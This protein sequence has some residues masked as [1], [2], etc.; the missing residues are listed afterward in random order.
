MELDGYCA[1]LRLAFEYNGEQHYTRV[2]HFHEDAEAFA[3][4]R[5]TDDWKV[6]LC[7][8]LGIRLFVIPYTI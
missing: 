2:G 5:K 1:T 6:Q 8:A 4:R 3:K 7:D